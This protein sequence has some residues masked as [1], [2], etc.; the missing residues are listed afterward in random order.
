MSN[1]I[2]TTWKVQ[3]PREAVERFAAELPKAG[4]Y[5]SRKIKTDG[6]TTIDQVQITASIS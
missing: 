6:E 4:Y 3:G 2:E 1:T 5:N